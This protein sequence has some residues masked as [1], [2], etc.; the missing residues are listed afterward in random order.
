MSATPAFLRRIG[1]DPHEGGAKTSSCEGC[2]DLWELESGDIAVIG[3]RIT[4]ETA[5]RLPA[6]AGWGPDE[7]IVVVP[8]GTIL[9]AK[10]A[11]AA[12]E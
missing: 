8:R 4:S 5:G 12:L 2:P 9:R 10:A 1:P 3:V 7:E 6:T 11:L